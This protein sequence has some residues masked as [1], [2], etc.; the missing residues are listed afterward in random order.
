MSHTDPSLPKQAD[1]ADVLAGAS[2]GVLVGL[3]VGLSSS[4]VTATVVGALVALLAG[5]FGL[6]DKIPVGLTGVGAR[7]VMAFS[8]A[9]S[10]ALIAG[11]MLRTHQVLSPSTAHIRQQLSDIGISDKV[12][13]MHMIRL[14]RFGL[15]PPGAQALGKDGEA[16][17]KVIASSQTTLYAE[18][19]DFCAELQTM[20]RRSAGTKDLLKHFE[21]GT[22]DAQRTMRAIAALPDDQQASALNAAPVFLCAR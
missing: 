22:P 12:E 11:V 8:L 18:T 14:L 3:L 6:A 7:R 4:P 16:A 9:C 10:V 17:A 2:L 20:L 1:R 21:T 15:L 5:V 19:S 13:Q